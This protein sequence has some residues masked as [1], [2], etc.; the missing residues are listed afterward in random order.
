MIDILAAIESVTDA[1]TVLHARRRHNDTAAQ[2]SVTAAALALAV[3][4]ARQSSCAVL[5][6]LRADPAEL[7]RTLDCTL[8]A[9]LVWRAVDSAERAGESPLAAAE[10]G[11]RAALAYVDLVAPAAT[12]TPGTHEPGSCAALAILEVQAR[13][14]ICHSMWESA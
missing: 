13:L 4:V 12:S 11:L 6:L 10:T 1:A 8:G 9:V 14:G 7:T 2:E 3:P 5:A